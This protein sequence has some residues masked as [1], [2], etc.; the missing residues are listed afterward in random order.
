MADDVEAVERV[1]DDRLA[2]G[3]RDVA[4][5]E[6][7]LE[8]L[9]DRQVVQQVVALE[10]EADVLLL[11]LEALLLV[12]AMDLGFAETEFPGPSRSHGDRGY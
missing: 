3:P 8:V 11:Q 10:H 4:V 1:A 5:G 7:D 2:L 9:V 6:R 12:Q